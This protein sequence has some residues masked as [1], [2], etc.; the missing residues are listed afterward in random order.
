MGEPH[1]EPCGDE[2]LDARLGRSLALLLGD[3]TPPKVDGDTPWSPFF[4]PTRDGFRAAIA[5][6]SGILKWDRQSLS[7]PL[8]DGE[9]AS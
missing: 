4:I 9:G 5:R 7:L 3:A 2:T 1:G 8:I 6:Q